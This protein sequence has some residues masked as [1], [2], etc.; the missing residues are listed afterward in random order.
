MVPDTNQTT[1]YISVL[2]PAFNEADH[3]PR[4]LE[5]VHVAFA[6]L[7][8]S[9]FE[10]IV[11]DNNSD[12]ETAA[13]AIQHGA[14]KV[15]FEAHNQISKARNTAAKAATGRLL[16]FIDADSLLPP[17]LLAETLSAMATNKVI[18]GGAQV[19]LD[20]KDVPVYVHLGLTGWNTL[21]RTMSW[22]AGSY[23]FCCHEAFKKAGGFDER[24]YASEEIAF[25]RML[26]R[27][28][29]Q[30][31][32][33]VR[34]LQRVSIVTSARKAK[35]YSFLQTVRQVLRCAWPG[36]LRR[37]DR[38]GFWYERGPTDKS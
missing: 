38:C 22:A 37:R 6:E 28:A 3:L 8:R 31:R 33:H 13:V 14:T 11:C 5:S 34:I 21:S 32:K 30:Q 24:L 2:V 4:L 18:G 12:D 1:P 19:A 17:E 25:S 7:G 15:V 23:L 27:V 29:R 20:T 16:I 10:I 26:K 35:Q 36:S 9:D